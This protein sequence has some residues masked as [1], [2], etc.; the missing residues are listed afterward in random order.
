MKTTSRTFKTFALAASILGLS[1]SPAAQAWDV[2]TSL[3]SFSSLYV[4]SWSGPGLG[5]NWTWTTLQ[6]GTSTTFDTNG[7]IPND[8]M[9]QAWDGNAW[10][11]TYYYNEINE[12][13]GTASAWA[14]W[15]HQDVNTEIA[16]SVNATVYDEF[17]S[18]SNGE[19]MGA[20]F[21]YDFQFTLD[22]S[23]NATISYADGDAYVYLES[24]AGE[25]G[26]AFAGLKLYST[27]VDIND[28]GGAN[29]AYFSND[30]SLTATPEGNL[31]EGYL[32]GMDYTFSNMT[33]NSITYNLRL[34]GT[35]FVFTQAVPEPETYA[36]LL[37]GLGL[38]GFAV[39]R[40]R[41]V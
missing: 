24:M 3:N 41:G 32:T 12:P 29:M 39:R 7:G 4:S 17:S 30:M 23:S 25:S 19:A 11:D 21:A 9:Y 27:D 35:A 22:P 33:G 14:S 20:I 2:S 31:V 8:F 6:E 36:M 1:A 10:P 34:E 13:G 28:F 26:V 15:S 18:L 5:V 38:V 16:D 40:R 37:A